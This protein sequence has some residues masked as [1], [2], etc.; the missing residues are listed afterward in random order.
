MSY[1]TFGASIIVELEFGV[2]FVSLPVIPDIPVFCKAFVFSGGLLLLAILKCITE[3]TPIPIAKA[4]L[5]QQ[6]IIL[7][8]GTYFF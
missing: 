4:K 8:N 2:L 7:F 5:A 3:T 6:A 1:D